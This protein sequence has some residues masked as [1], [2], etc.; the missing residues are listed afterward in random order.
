MER[1]GHVRAGRGEH[2]IP[3]WRR[4]NRLRASDHEREGRELGDVEQGEDRRGRVRGGG[5][6]GAHGLGW[7]GRGDEAE[8][9]SWS[10]ARGVFAGVSLE[11]STL[12][13]DD[14]ANKNLYGKELSAKQIVREGQ[15]ST[16]AAGKPLT[17]L[18]H[19]TTPKRG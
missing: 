14:D 13:S 19:K 3:D 10:K 16:P 8:I 2:R 12:R 15:V 9:L 18:L 5:A 11:G 1:P 17:G 6:G 7:Y 4:G